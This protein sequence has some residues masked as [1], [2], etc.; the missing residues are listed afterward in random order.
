MLRSTTGDIA[1]VLTNLAGAIDDVDPAVRRLAPAAREGQRLMQE[2]SAAAPPLGR[3]VDRL[4][5]TANPLAAVLPGTKKL[6]CEVR[7]M[8]AYLAPYAKDV[9]S[10]VQGMASATNYYDANGHAA[11]LYV[12]VGADSP[13]VKSSEILDKILNAGIFDG[14]HLTGWNPYPEPGKADDTE[15]GARRNG[16]G[17]KGAYTRVKAAC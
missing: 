5:R 9:T 15:T 11:R 17:E 1:P 13:V 8:L 10:L 7:P 12:A 6:L 16:P 4:E 2:I 3:V 14:I